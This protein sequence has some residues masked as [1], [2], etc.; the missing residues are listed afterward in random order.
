MGLPFSRTFI[1][2]VAGVCVHLACNILVHGGNILYITN[3]LPE[4]HDVWGALS[5]GTAVVSA[6][7]GHQRHAM[8]M[9]SAPGTGTHGTPKKPKKRLS[10]HKVKTKKAIV[11]TT[12]T[13][14]DPYKFFDEAN[15]TR[16]RGGFKFRVESFAGLRDNAILFSFSDL[17]V[18]NWT[19]EQ[20]K[21]HEDV[22]FFD[23][24]RKHTFHREYALPDSIGTRRNPMLRDSELINGAGSLIS[25]ADTGL[26]YNHE[27]FRDPIRSSADIPKMHVSSNADFSFVAERTRKSM[28]SK[29]AGYVS[30]EYF[31]L[32]THETRVTDFM[33]EKNGHGTHVS[34]IAAG[35]SRRAPLADSH[36]RLLFID[37]DDTDSKNANGTFSVPGSIWWLMQMSYDSGSRIFSNSWGAAG[38]EY[39]SYA[40]EVDLFVY[41]YPDMSVV[42][43][44]G[45][46]GPEACTIAS[47][48]IAK[49]ALTVGSSLNTQESWLEYAKTPSAWENSLEYCTNLSHVEANPDVYA[50]V[51][52]SSFSSRGPTR[53]GRI[54][55]EIVV[56][57]EW[58]RSA[59][60][61]TSNG[62]L[63]MRGTSQA[64][65]LAAHL[66]SIVDEKLRSVYKWQGPISASLRRAILVACANPMAD[67]YSVKF[68]L[69]RFTHRL[70]PEYSR[71]PIRLGADDG[72]G[73]VSLQPFLNKEL[74]PRD[75][76]NLSVKEGNWKKFVFRNTGPPGKKIFVMSY[77][78]VPSLD[79]ERVLVNNVNMR[80][81]LYKSDGKLGLIVNGNN[82][83]GMGDDRNP[84]ERITVYANTGDEIHLTLSTM[85]HMKF[86][87]QLVSLVFSASLA[88]VPGRD[89]CSEYDLPKHCGGYGSY[90]YK[91]DLKTKRF[92]Q[93][94]CSDLTRLEECTS[95]SMCS[96][97]AFTYCDDTVLC[98]NTFSA[99]KSKY[100]ALRRSLSSE[101]KAHRAAWYVY[102][103]VCLLGMFPPA[104]KLKRYF[105]QRY[106][107]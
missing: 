7:G 31:D 61:G 63:L 90:W 4:A 11:V 16:F 20:A 37:L 12:R 101:S 67:A 84:T 40:Y 106:H 81:V 33:D 62:D 13:P 71:D 80:L 52:L 70:E 88:E 19:L 3:D 17:S 96:D 79:D 64:A 74:E 60:A 21:E 75:N 82:A 85:H 65:P 91:C 43:S 38:C 87:V 14:I 39:T 44:A 73:R 22:L 8:P 34:G 103:A 1:L 36:A 68:N 104:L 25:I 107:L 9:G 49:N 57:G 42:F 27:I 97:G 78:D 98:S 30:L 94:S 41:K 35:Y 56:P 99:Q 15:L 51:H 10:S 95:V 46:S 100:S 83:D 48:G 6:S 54:K 26:D 55:P 102:V 2:L 72:F 5:D 105:K 50:D 92:D 76:I 32:E 18:A 24:I 53:D 29:V 69:N 45:N 66:L 89:D 28:H 47:P 58:I 93:A 77:T 86:N 59:R 23:Y